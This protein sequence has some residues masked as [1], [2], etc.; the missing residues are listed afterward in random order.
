MLILSRRAD[1]DI[2]LSI[3]EGLPAQR[4][5]VTVLSVMGKQVRIGIEADK[6]IEV[7]RAEV[8]QY[9]DSGH[10]TRANTPAPLPIA[11]HTGNT[12]TLKK[13]ETP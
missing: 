10:D 11:K 1:E 9:I 12:L 5:T 2:V 13:R 4:V 6:A 8:Q 3:P 7:H